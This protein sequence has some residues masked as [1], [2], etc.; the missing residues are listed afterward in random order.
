MPLSGPPFRSSA[1]ISLPRST[2]I[3]GRPRA[4]CRNLGQSLEGRHVPR[5]KCAVEIIVLRQQPFVGKAGI[6][7]LAEPSP[8]ERDVLPLDAHPF[9]KGDVVRSLVT[10]NSAS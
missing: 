2:V 1:A 6:L 10:K 7:D 5:D 8:H 3:I 4:P 9:A